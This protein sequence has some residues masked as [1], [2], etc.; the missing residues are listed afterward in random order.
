MSNYHKFE[1][2]NHKKQL[3]YF[4]LAYSL[5]TFFTLISYYLYGTVE[6]PWYLTNLLDFCFKDKYA[7]FRI[8][9]Y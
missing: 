8:I 4:F 1:F 6:D 7:R 5:S 3:D 2:D 9:S